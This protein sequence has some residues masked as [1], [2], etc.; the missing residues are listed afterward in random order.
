MQ[1]NYDVIRFVQ[2]NGRYHVVM[3]STEG[4]LLAHYITHNATWK[5]NNFFSVICDLAKEIYYLEHSNG[6]EIY[7]FLTPYNVIVERNGHVALLKFSESHTQKYAKGIQPFITQDE[8]SHYVESYGKIIQFIL[9]QTEL[10]P[11]LTWNETR[12]IKKVISKCQ[13]KKI[14]VVDLRWL[15]LG[16]FILLFF[17]SQNKPIEIET[18]SEDQYIA[19]AMSEEE[20][21]RHRNALNICEE[22]SELFPE[23]VEVKLQYVRLL[24]SDLGFSREEKQEKLEGF[25]ALYP[26]LET[27]KRL[28]QLQMEL[29]YE[30]EE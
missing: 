10:N 30:S 24:L 1:Q 3:D 22:A 12:K 25:L 16:G 2:Q 13:K 5:K 20:N 15:F 8:S 29:G 4:E 6:I 9:S 26:V 14:K 17:I 18:V 19:L 23:G 21:G 11:R 7:P 27:E 28:E